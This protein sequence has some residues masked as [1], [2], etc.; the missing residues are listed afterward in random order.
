[1]KSLD[2]LRS[3]Q[4]TIKIISALTISK[5]VLK[6]IASAITTVVLCYLLRNWHQAT[7]AVVHYGTNPISFSCREIRLLLVFGRLHLLDLLFS[8]EQTNRKST[9]KTNTQYENMRINN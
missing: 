7:S 1:M 8:L 5:L 9:N 2:P 4:K 6:R 3:T